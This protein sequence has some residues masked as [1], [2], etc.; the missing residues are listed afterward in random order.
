M[1]LFFR[2]LVK[3]LDR[4]RAGWR[5]DTVILLDNAPYHKSKATMTL[6]AAL[7]LPVMF[8]GPHSYAAA[9]CEL[10]FAA[11]KSKDANPNRVPTTKR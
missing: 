3:K 4:E 11:F 10:W 9:P 1:E 6:F 8:T 7:D 5:Q 2:Q